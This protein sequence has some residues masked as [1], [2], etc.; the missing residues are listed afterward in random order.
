MF[1]GDRQLSQQPNPISL[2]HWNAVECGLSPSAASFAAQPPHGLMADQKLFVC[3]E[4]GLCWL[5]VQGL[6]HVTNWGWY[7]LVAQRQTSVSCRNC[8]GRAGVGAPR[9]SVIDHTDSVGNYGWICCPALLHKNHV[10]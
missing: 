1:Y 5:G 9:K 8:V 7:V 3:A 6:V 2:S 4:M 10:Y